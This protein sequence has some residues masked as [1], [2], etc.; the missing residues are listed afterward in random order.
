MGEPVTDTADDA[1][2]RR[3]QEDQLVIT[4]L[5]NK[6]VSLGTEVTGLLPKMENFLGVTVAIMIGAITLGATDDHPLIFVLLPFPLIVLYVYLLQ[7]N[8]E[9]LSRAGHKRFLEAKVNELLERPVML[10]ESHV[11]L[12]L[13]G[14]THYGRWSIIMIQSTMVILL[15][16]VVA[17]AIANVGTL[18]QLHWKIVFWTGLNLGAVNLAVAAVEQG[19]AYQLGYN[20]ARAGYSGDPPPVS[21]L[22]GP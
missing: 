14:P 10:E 3:S 5:S 13:Q 7:A 18:E 16:G 15:L 8:T 19:R 20:A 12:T 2:G 21:S 9:M 4:V 11:A 6:A 22:L 17:L 1:A